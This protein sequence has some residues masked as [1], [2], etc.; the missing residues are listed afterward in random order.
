MNQKIEKWHG[1]GTLA[2]N[3][4]IGG[5]V[6]ILI[7]SGIVTFYH[8]WLTANYTETLYYDKALVA[9][10]L[11][12]NLGEKYQIKNTPAAARRTAATPSF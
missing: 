4:L 7:V 1:S 6:L 9:A 8:Q 2:R 12:A 11:A 5:M 10:D 3:F